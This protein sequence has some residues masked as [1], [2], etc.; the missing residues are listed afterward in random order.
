MDLFWFV[1]IL[2]V[3]V[4]FYHVVLFGLLGLYAIAAVSLVPLITVTVE[5]VSEQLELV[6][7]VP[8]RHGEG[9]VPVGQDPIAAAAQVQVV[10]CLWVSTDT[11]T[12]GLTQE[13]ATDFCCPGNVSNVL[14]QSV[15]QKC[16]YF[17]TVVLRGQRNFQEVKSRCKVS[18]QVYRCLNAFSTQQEI[19]VNAI[20]YCTHNDKASSALMY[21]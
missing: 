1:L 4:L 5:P 13:F 10:W 12:V 20:L 21:A 6:L 15:V 16:L 3:Q 9:A 11:A 17:G 18:W 7:R 19:N 8:S 2:L 14:T